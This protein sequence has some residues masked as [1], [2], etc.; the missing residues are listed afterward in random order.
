[1]RPPPPPPTTSLTTS[2]PAMGGRRTQNPKCFFIDSEE[3]SKQQGQ[4]HSPNLSPFVNPQSHT[5]HIPKLEDFL[6]DSSSM[7]CYSNSQTET[8]DSSSLPHMY[9]QSCTYFGGNHH[10]FHHS[11]SPHRA[12][13]LHNMHL[14]I[15]L[16]ILSSSTSKTQVAPSSLRFSFVVTKPINPL[17]AKA[18][19]GSIVSGF[20]SA[21]EACM[22]SLSSIK[23]PHSL[24]FE[25]SV[26]TKEKINLAG[27]EEYIVRRSISLTKFVFYMFMP[28]MKLA[29]QKAQCSVQHQV[30][31]RC[32][33]LLKKKTFIM[34]VPTFLK[35]LQEKEQ[36]DV[37]KETNLLHDLK[38]DGMEK[39]L[40][41]LL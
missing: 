6:D 12:S 18:T 9:D 15:F 41:C 10:H 33:Q 3:Q 29:F 19:R 39:L 16:Q 36:V 32:H 38:V 31:R 24:D 13:N 14:C 4:S 17:R 11:P 40:M 37:F 27:H 7:V 1:M 22:V 8:Q 28:T 23:S 2:M 5:Q 34:H 25:T 30:V 20:G 26:F 35:K 21:F